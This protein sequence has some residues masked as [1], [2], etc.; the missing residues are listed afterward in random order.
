MKTFLENEGYAVSKVEL[1]QSIIK[2]I[3][4]LLTY[5]LLYCKIIVINTIIKL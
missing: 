1:L 4:N 3:F 5:E 2:Y